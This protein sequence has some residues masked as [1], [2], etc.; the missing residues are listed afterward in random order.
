[1]ASIRMYVSGAKPQPMRL[2]VIGCVPFIAKIHRRR[3]C[4]GA[5]IVT[6]IIFMCNISAETEEETIKQ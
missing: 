2:C 6:A 3:T 1:M 4:V 5:C